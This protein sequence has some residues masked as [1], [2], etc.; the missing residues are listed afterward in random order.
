MEELNL[1]NENYA[2]NA[3]NAPHST[4]PEVTE[5]QAQTEYRTVTNE[6]VINKEPQNDSVP[7]QQSFADQNYGKGYSYPYTYTP[8]NNGSYSNP[9]TTFNQTTNNPYSGSGSASYTFSNNPSY[10]AEQKA[11]E[12]KPKKKKGSALKVIA[13]ILCCA[14]LSGITGLGAAYLTYEHLAKDDSTPTT[15]QNNEP[16]DNT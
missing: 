5:E 15:P 14:I 2:N 3:D 4:T 11:T 13:I 8:H 6:T 7:Y 1:N 9:Y 16:A 10:G 12:P